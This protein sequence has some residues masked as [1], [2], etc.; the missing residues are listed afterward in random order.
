MT[1]TDECG[2]L[3]SYYCTSPHGMNLYVLKKSDNSR[4]LVSKMGGKKKFAAYLT[5]EIFKL[6]LFLLHA[7]N[8]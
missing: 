5:L 8:I 4:F 1:T 6:Y 3:N 7:Y 2:I